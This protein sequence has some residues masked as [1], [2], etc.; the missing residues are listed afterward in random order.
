MNTVGPPIY[1]HCVSVWY[2]TSHDS[3]CWY[4]TLLFWLPYVPI[5]RLSLGVYHS[6]RHLSNHCWFPSSL[7]PCWVSLA[8]GGGVCGDSSL[9]ERNK[10]QLRRRCCCC[11]GSSLILKHSFVLPTD[12]RSTSARLYQHRERLFSAWLSFTVSS[13]VFLSKNV[14]FFFGLCHNQS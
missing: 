9:Q 11:C 7:Q 13:S 10:I 6:L 5:E 1:R 3:I 4:I 8:G 14:T 12:A 2:C